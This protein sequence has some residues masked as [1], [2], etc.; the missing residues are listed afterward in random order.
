MKKILTIGA[1]AAAFCLTVSFGFAIE[2]ATA[3]VVYDFNDPESIVKAAQIFLVRSDFVSMTDITELNERKRVENTA[4][5]MKIDRGLA[6]EVKAQA[7]LIES[8]E[9]IG[10][11]VITNEDMELAV[12]YTKWFVRND[13]SKPL[14]NVKDIEYGA[15]KS[16]ILVDYLLRKF[17][18]KWKIITQRTR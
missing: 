11:D 1:F 14:P 7:K 3:R 16:V 4:E 6:A 18:G 17:D 8:F 13:R 2:S 5:Q 15:G 10:T 9:I 12:V